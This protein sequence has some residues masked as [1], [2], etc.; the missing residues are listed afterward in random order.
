MSILPPFPDKPGHVT[1]CC[2][3]HQ[4]GPECEFCS[5]RLWHR[6]ASCPLGQRKQSWSNSQPG[7]DVSSSSDGKT[8]FVVLMKLLSNQED[9]GFM[10]VSVLNSDLQWL[11]SCLIR[12]QSFT[13]LSSQEPLAEDAGDFN[14]GYS[15]V[16][17]CILYR[18]TVAPDPTPNTSL[19][20]A[21][22]VCLPSPQVW[23][24]AHTCPHLPA[25]SPSCCVLSARVAW[26]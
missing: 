8:L 2:S 19:H 10:A 21:C 9:T 18:R 13:S 20:C 23:S 15:A 6:P 14:L 17:K 24:H 7:P 12:L 11:S 1:G 4:P 5:C 22:T 16:T 25:L 26:G 3:T